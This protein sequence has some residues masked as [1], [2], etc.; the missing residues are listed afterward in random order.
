LYLQNPTA[1]AAYAS[2]VQSD[3]GANSHYNGMLFSLQH[4]FASNFTLL[5]NYTWSHCI[6]DG[7]FGGELAGNYYQDP[8]NRAGNRG[9]CNF[10]VRH[11]SN[12]S[13]VARSPFAGSSWKGRLLGGW[14]LSPIVSIASGIAINITSGRDNSLVGINNDRPDAVAG[15]NAYSSDPNPRTFLNAAAFAQNA[16]GTFGNLGRDVIHGPGRINF[17]LALTRSF[18]LTERFRLEARG[19]AFNAINH[20]NYNNPTTS[21]NSATFGKIQGAADPRILQVSM[22]LHF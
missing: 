2:I 7:D 1:G 10:D 12:T 16:M 8:N 13:L 22:K 19:E 17:D 6:S 3:Q 20:V 15:I 5:F 21:L 4:R 11:L 18:R 14:Q 9:D